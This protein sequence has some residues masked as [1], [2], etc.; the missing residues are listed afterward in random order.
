MCFYGMI[1][2]FED[3]QHY[4]LSSFSLQLAPIKY[5]LSKLLTLMF[6]LAL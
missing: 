2:E 6:E 3:K 1:C 4:C 5:P